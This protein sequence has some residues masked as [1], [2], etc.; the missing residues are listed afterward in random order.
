[1][2]GMSKMRSYI[3]LILGL[4]LL[5]VS[6]MA[7]NCP[8][9]PDHTDELEILFAQVQAVP[10]EGA[11]RPVMN[12]MW[13]LWAKAPDETAQEILNRGM[14]K[15]A[16][17]DL[18][19]AMADFETLIAYCPDFAEGYNQRGF[20]AFIRQDYLAALKDLN[21]VLMINPYHLGA[22]SGRALTFMALG[23]N[24]DARSDLLDALKLNPWLPER[25]FLDQLG[26]PADTEL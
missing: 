4:A 3:P 21:K 5:P 2:R 20:V 16:S 15:R 7:Q 8:P 11:A 13:E 22:L 1:M 18:L 14:R 17:H 10:T 6:G 19:G 23:R 12:K 9:S 24:A 25:R 26:P